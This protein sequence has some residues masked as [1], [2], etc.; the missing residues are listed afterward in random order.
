MQTVHITMALTEKKIGFIGTGKMGSAIIHGL[1]ASNL[2]ESSNIYAS[3]I[4]EMA[5]ERIA[6]KYGITPCTDNNEVVDRSDVIILA[7]K[8]QILDTVLLSIKNHV[9]AR[10]LVTSIAAGTPIQF[11]AKHLPA[12]TKIIRVMPNITAT[13]RAAPSALSIGSGVAQE[14]VQT[15]KHIFDSVGS[16]V[17]VPEDLMD[18]VTG[19]SGSGPAFV[20]VFIEAMT[21]A[22][23]YCGLDRN[24]SL[25]LA[26]QT[27]LGSAKMILETDI[28][29]ASLKDMVTSPAG[30]TIEGIRELEMNNVRAGVMKAVIAAVER[31]KELGANNK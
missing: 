1:T 23:V 20:S 6:D 12:G 11:I 17:I 18:A 8:P 16:T 5:L 9:H 24:T 21:D 7:V 22:G 26:A 2:I 30:T 29:P 14:D 27:V 13:V 4:D 15:A 19:L 31:S 10:H 3:D 25:A 28:H